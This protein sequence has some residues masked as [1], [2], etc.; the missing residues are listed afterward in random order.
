MQAPR[1]DSVI[2]DQ[3]SSGGLGQAMLG[4]RGTEALPA[5]TT[6]P[7]APAGTSGYRCR[8]PRCRS[9]AVTAGMRDQPPGPCA[10]WLGR[11]AGHAGALL[12][13][14]MSACVKVGPDFVPPDAPRGRSLAGGRRP[15]DRHDPTRGS[16]VVA[17]VRRSQALRLDP[18]RAAA[19][20]EPA[21][22]GG[23][24][25]PGARATGRHDRRSLSAEAAAVR[26]AHVQAPE[27]ARLLERLGA[28][29]GAR[30]RP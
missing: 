21:D 19:E 7:T 8:A 22:C 14:A 13:L 27:R 15:A 29:R 30:D 9:V 20:P 5:M 11:R 16:G 26:R 4:A 3:R 17:Q 23:A 6:L 24:G 18:D 10:A 28:R 25:A 2:V 12:V 1:S